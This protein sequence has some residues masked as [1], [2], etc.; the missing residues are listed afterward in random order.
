MMDQ[1]ETKETL[2]MASRQGH[3]RTHPPLLCLFCCRCFVACVCLVEWCWWGLS[4]GRTHAGR[5]ICSPERR[6]RE[7]RRCTLVETTLA[8]ANTAN[9]QQGAECIAADTCNLCVFRVREW[10]VCC[11]FPT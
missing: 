4:T 11:G 7:G 9:A 3:P 8:A 1:D 10:F 2:S 5:D 6:K